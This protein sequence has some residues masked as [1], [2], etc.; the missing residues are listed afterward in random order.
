MIQF[1]P[2]AKQSIFCGDT[3]DPGQQ[4]FLKSNERMSGAYPQLQIKNVSTNLLKTVLPPRIRPPPNKRKLVPEKKYLEGCRNSEDQNRIQM[5]PGLS[6][7]STQI[8][9]WGAI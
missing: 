2:E 8:C 5:H 3:S 7:F 9:V 1:D 6:I 4:I